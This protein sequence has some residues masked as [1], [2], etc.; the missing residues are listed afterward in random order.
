MIYHLLFSMNIDN[1]LLQLVGK[2]LN[3]YI[4]I[5]FHIV[6]LTKTISVRNL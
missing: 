3:Q 1:L 2:L 4:Y 5:S 6:S